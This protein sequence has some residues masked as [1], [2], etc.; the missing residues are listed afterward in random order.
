M[1][2]EDLRDAFAVSHET[3]AH[4][5]TN[6]ATRHLGIQV[7]FMR[8]HESGTIYKAYE[9]D[10]VHFPADATGAIEGQ[11][12]CR[13]GRRGRSSPHDGQVRTTQY[14]DTPS[15]TYWCTALTEETPAGAFSV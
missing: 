3:A 9:N 8:V 7:H 11:R 14:T 2:I 6:L 15:G 10:G 5:F 12:V 4:R 13:T 1:A